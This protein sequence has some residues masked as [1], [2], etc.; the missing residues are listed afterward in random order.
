MAIDMP[1]GVAA[2]SGCIAQT[3]VAASVTVTFGLPKLGQIFY[4]GGAYTG[5]LLV[6][7]IGIP[8][9]LLEEEKIQQALLDIHLVK[10]LL[11][12]RAA[13]VHKNSCGRVL[14]IAGSRGYTGAAALTAESALRSSGDGQAGNSGRTA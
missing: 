8:R 3:A 2:D 14:A 9:T 5:K 10:K 4:P 13:D 7:G 12:P 1:S 11:V 6:D